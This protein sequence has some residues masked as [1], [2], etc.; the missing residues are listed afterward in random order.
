MAK[1]GELKGNSALIIAIAEGN[2]LSDSARLAGVSLRTATRRVADPEF[3]KRVAAARDQIFRE[4]V[5]KLVSAATKAVDTLEDLLASGSPTV[6]LGAARAILELGP[7][8]R[9]QTEMEARI[10]ALEAKQDAK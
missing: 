8:I 3:C 9:E 4:V 1:S 7:R 6:K 2:N 10:A 5:G